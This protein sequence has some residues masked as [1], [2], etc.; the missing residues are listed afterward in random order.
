LLCA[1]PGVQLT[2]VVIDCLMTAVE[3]VAARVD[4][5]RFAVV[6]VVVY[7]PG[8]DAVQSTFYDEL[9]S[10]FETVATY[11]IP[12]Y[13]VGDFNVRFDRLNDPHT[14]QLL[15]LVRSYG[16]DVRST[17]AT[18]RQGGTIDAVITRQ[19]IPGPLVRPVD[20]GLSDHH[21]L[22]WSVCAERPQSDAARISVRPWRQLDI[23]RLRSALLTSPL[24][25]SDAWPED[26]NVMADMFDDVITGL[27]D[28]L[29]PVRQFVRRPRPSDPWFDGNVATLKRL[30]QEAQTH[31][32][33][34]PA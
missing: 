3:V 14:C 19:D 30:D 13:V 7:R 12:V 15:D 18:H 1:I 33:C 32:C 26:V 4:V 25:Q 24:C 6:V 28:Q 8:S 5:G 9:A 2:P 11:Q 31:S 34:G 27:L 17:T 16:F 23:D 22:E 10:V 21:L 20:V 29:V